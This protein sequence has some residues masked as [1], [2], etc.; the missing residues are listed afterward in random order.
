MYSENCHYKLYDPTKSLWSIFVFKLGED[1][2][3]NKKFLSMTTWEKYKHLKNLL[4]F[5]AYIPG[6]FKLLLL[7]FSLMFNLALQLVR[8]HR[9]HRTLFF[10]SSL[11]SRKRENSTGTEAVSH[12]RENM[13]HS[14]NVTV[15]L[16]GITLR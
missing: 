13:W 15:R 14:Q 3:A 12:K 9:S 16:Y 6:I 2:G 4:M 10:I 7:I 5:H 1:S 8:N 11:D